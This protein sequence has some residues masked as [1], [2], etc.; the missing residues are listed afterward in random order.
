MNANAAIQELLSQ[1]TKIEGGP[2]W[3]LGFL[4]DGNVILLS[5]TPTVRGK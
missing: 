4:P 1:F 3:F 2:I 5:S